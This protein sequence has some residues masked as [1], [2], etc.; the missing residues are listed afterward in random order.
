MRPVLVK[1]CGLTDPANALACVEAGAS[2]LGLNFYAPSPRSV[3]VTQALSVVEAVRE[4]AKLVGLFVDHSLDEIEKILD[5]IPSIQFVQ[6]QGSESV[7]FL[8]ACR[9]LPTC[10]EIIRAFRIKDSGDVARM[11]DYLELAHSRQSSPD[12]ILVDAL[13]SGQAGG[14][15][16]AIPLELL[17]SLSSHPRLILAGGLNPA[18]VA[19]RIQ[20]V[21]PWMVDVASGVETAPGWK[22]P[23]QVAAFVAATQQSSGEP[24]TG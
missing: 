2:Y 24:S 13:V 3:S 1:V 12:A 21:H 22:D 4:R 16:Q 6:L 10:P 5:T 7:D 20:L 14:T 23:V 17:K 8:A 19:E 15:G 9:D 11:N 18:N